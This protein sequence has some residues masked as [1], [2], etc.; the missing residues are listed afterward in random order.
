MTETTVVPVTAAVVIKS[1]YKKGL[2]LVHT[3]DP[4]PDGPVDII[5]KHQHRF[6]TFDLASKQEALGFDFM[7]FGFLHLHGQVKIGHLR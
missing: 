7:N 4:V 2:Q 6:N 5:R 1:F 3:S